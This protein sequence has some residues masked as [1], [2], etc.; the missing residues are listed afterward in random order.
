VPWMASGSFAGYVS[1]QGGRM[2]IVVKSF[3]WVTTD[4]ESSVGVTAF[5]AQ[6]TA[7]G[8]GFV[9]RGDTVLLGSSN[10]GQRVTGSDSVVFHL[11]LTGSL[12][13]TTSWLGFQFHLPPDRT[14]Y[15]HS[16]FTLNGNPRT[17]GPR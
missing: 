17:S 7:R 3:S 12:D 16:A 2:T 15:A 14:T 8:W 11:Q 6:P 4:A 13:S 10:A 1:S 9:G 5:V